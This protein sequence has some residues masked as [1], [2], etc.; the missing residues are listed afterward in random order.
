MCRK[1][2]VYLVFFGA[3]TSLLTGCKIALLVVE[4]GD[5]GSQSGRF[6]CAQGDIC[7][8]EVNSTDFNDIFIAD[9]GEGYVFSHWLSGENMLCGTTV[10]PRC[11]IDLRA[12]EGNELIEAFVASDITYYILPVFVAEEEPEPVGL[13][14]ELQAKY[15]SSCDRCHT[16]G[17]FGA[18]VIHDEAA[19]APRLARGLD[20]LLNSVKSGRGAMPAGGDCGNC[21]DDDYR[22]LINYMS[23][24]AP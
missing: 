1:F 3:V 19:W 4:G 14:P 20:S 22:A 12:F 2:V 15:D 21:S 23:G 6:A 18:P 24:P 10:G 9:P 5:L 17:A 8:I 7:I 16:N 13:S 11:T